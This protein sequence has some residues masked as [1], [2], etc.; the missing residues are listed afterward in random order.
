MQDSRKLQIENTQ[1]YMISHAFLHSCIY[2]IF[3]AH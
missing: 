2:F 3:I 1:L